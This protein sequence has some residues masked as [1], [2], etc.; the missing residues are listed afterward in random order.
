MNTTTDSPPAPASKTVRILVAEDSPLN[1]Q[2]ALKQLENLGYQ[3]DAVA[4]GSEA[5]EAQARNA[6]DIILMDC[7]MPGTNG[8]DATSLIR[9]REQAHAEAGTPFKRAC[10]IAMTANTE[11][12]NR[13]RCLAA[14]MDDFINKPVH[15]PELEAALRRAFSD[16]AAAKEMDQIVD[17]VAIAALRQLRKPNEP[18]PIGKFI[19]LFLREAPAAL[20]TMNDAISKN[21]ATALSRTMSAAS[22]LKGSADNLGARHLAALCEEIEQTAKNW[23]LTDA[24]PILQ[25]AYQE[26][27]RVRAVLEKV[28]R[29]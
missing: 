24:K 9:D 28:K 7:Q 23:I 8:Y 19:D 6:Y 15:L 21:D 10:I 4:D 27:D 12:D 2:V 14:G 16:R 22:A 3:A 17:P 25:R 13:E 29:G 11:T 1:Q 5:V 18:D 26:F 20:D